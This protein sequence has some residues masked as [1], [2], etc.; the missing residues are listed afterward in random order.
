MYV[1]QLLSAYG[2]CVGVKGNYVPAAGFPQRNDDDDGYFLF[3]FI[4]PCI[5]PFRLK[6]D[7]GS[8]S[9][10][11]LQAQTITSQTLAM[12]KKGSCR[13]RGSVA[14]YCSNYSRGLVGRGSDLSACHQRPRSSLR[15]TTPAAGFTDYF[16]LSG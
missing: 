4:F 15:P 2:E 3:S 16:L 14:T 13:L 11:H 10:V 12:S 9:F 7:L 6:I 8:I 1:M 5:F